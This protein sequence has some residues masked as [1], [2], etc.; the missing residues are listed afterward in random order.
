[1]MMADELLANARGKALIADTGYD[2]NRFR[3]TVRD[4]GMKAVIGSKPERPRKLPKSRALYAKRYLV[5]IAQTQTI[6]S[7][8]ASRWS[9]VFSSSFVDRE[10]AA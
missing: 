2:S 4:N 8:C 3:Q 6:K 9:A 7:W 5:E 10:A 1:M